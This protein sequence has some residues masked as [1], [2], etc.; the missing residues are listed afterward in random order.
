MVVSISA[1]MKEPAAIQN[2]PTTI[3]AT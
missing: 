2:P 3:N 1:M